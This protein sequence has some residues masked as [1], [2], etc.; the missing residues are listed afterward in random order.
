M[1][2]SSIKFLLLGLIVLSAPSNTIADEQGKAK[3][4]AITKTTTD[5]KQIDGWV[6]QLGHQQLTKRVKAKKNLLNAGKTAIPSLA[7]AALSD[8]REAIE[9]SIDILGTLA[10]SEDEETS[11]AARVTLKMLTESDKPSTAER[12]KSVLNM[13]EADGI[14]PFEGWDKPGNPFARGGDV[15]RSVS[16]SSIN[17]VRTIRVVQNGRETVI[18]EVPGRGIRVATLKEEKQVE[19]LARDAADLKKR[20]PEA[21]A[22]YKQ[23]T[24]GNGITPDFGQFGGFPI[25]SAKGAANANGGQA[26]SFKTSGQGATEQMLVKQL[27]ELRR[28]MAGNPAMQE[29][30][31]KQIQA[32]SK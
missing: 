16:V 20:L 32:V 24:Q 5:I 21:F 3:E 30:L 26:F 29:L 25:G 11:D 27:Q 28:R 22:L 18:Q 13:K 9:R 7:K 12:A 10:Q 2:S 23:Y 17:G 4:A 14:K 19:I 31:D 1:T 8:R 6:E 15:N